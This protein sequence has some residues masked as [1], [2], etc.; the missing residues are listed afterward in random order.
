LGISSGSISSGRILLNSIPK[1]GTHLLE[2]VVLQFPGYRNSGFFYSH[3]HHGTQEQTLSEKSGIL[4]LVGNDF[5]VGAHMPYSPQ[6]AETLSRLLYKHV[7]LVRDPRSVVVSQYFHALKRK[8]NRV[9]E[10]IAS[11]TKTDGLWD[12]IRGIPGSGSFIGLAPIVD[13]YKSYCEWLSSDVHLVRF[14]SLVGE[15]GGG[16]G[17]EQREAIFSLG[18]YLGT[19]LSEHA[20]IE[21]AARVF[22][23]QANTFRSGQIGEWRQHLNGAQAEY[24]EKGLESELVLLGYS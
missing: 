2:K 17:R 12:V 15:K 8:T 1:A 16:S 6:D 21:I 4:R 23:E 13:Y 18:R 10:R 3:V 14:E 19:E 22:D 11:Q 24:I 9:H 5:F 7:L 20:I